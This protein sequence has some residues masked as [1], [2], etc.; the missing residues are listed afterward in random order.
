M[1]ALKY[2]KIQQEMIKAADTA[3]WKGYAHNPWLQ[4][5]QEENMVITNGYFLAIIPKCLF[6]LDP[7]K[8]TSG[9]KPFEGA[10]KIIDDKTYEH[11]I[12][13]KITEITQVNGKKMNL[14]KFKLRNGEELYADENLLKYFD[15]DL[16]SFTGTTKKNLLYIWECDDLIGAVLPVNYK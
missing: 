15:L 4:Y 16:C 13:M 9:K 1:D 3:T 10:K 8:A 6:F 7:E 5:E 12:D 2:L 11:A 14:H